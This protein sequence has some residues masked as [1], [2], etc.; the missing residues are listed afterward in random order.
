[1]SSC[2]HTCEATSYACCRRIHQS[3]PVGRPRGSGLF[4][5][6]SSWSYLLIHLLGIAVQLQEFGIHGI[7]GIQYPTQSSRFWWQVES[8]AEI[9]TKFAAFLLTYPFCSLL[10]KR[11]GNTS[12]LHCGVALTYQKDCVDE[13]LSELLV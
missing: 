4:A 13:N 1:M 6:K 8:T 10:F 2:L 7:H 11:T 5:L 12:T 3:W 9:W